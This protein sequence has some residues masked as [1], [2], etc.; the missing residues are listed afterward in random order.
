MF[1]RGMDD[2]IDADESGLDRRFLLLRGLRR[3]CMHALHI[4]LARSVPHE[5]ATRLLEGAQ[6]HPL[7][8]H[9]DPDWSCCQLGHRH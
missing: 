2:R 4:G 7:L 5:R 9:P 6:P 8:L 3:W 1:D